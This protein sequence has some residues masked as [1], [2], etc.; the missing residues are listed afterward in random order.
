MKIFI[1]MENEPTKSDQV[2]I[3]CGSGIVPISIAPTGEIYVLLGKEQEDPTWQYGSN[4]WSSFGGRP[5]P[6]EDEYATAAREFFEES[7]ATIPWTL[8][9]N[10]P[11]TGYKPLTRTLSDGEYIAKLCIILQNV[12]NGR[13]INK[14]FTS[15]IVKIPWCPSISQKF[16]SLYKRI[17]SLANIRLCRNLLQHELLA[18]TLSTIQEPLNDDCVDV[19]GEF[20][21]TVENSFSVDIAVEIPTVDD[22]I[23]HAYERSIYLLDQMKTTYNAL[24]HWVKCHPALTP[25]RLN[26]SSVLDVGVDP[27]YLEKKQVSWWS[28]SRLR[29]VINRGGVYRGDQFRHCFI[30]TLQIT[31]DIIESM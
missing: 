6:D 31:L 8:H 3:L 13:T 2:E 16:N 23:Q 26:T 19:D 7:M 12:R 10:I 11:L 28:V 9:Q 15:F 5:N 29:D 14:R 17:R 22:T 30:P 21:D 24:P 20:D 25:I 1:V 27:C 4:Q 18:N